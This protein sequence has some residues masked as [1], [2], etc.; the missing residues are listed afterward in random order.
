M[1][2]GVGRTGVVDPR[3]DPLETIRA[4]LHLVRGSV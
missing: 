1:L 4:R 2:A 3:A